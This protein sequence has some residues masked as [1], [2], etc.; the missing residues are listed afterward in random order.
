MSIRCDGHP[1]SSFPSM[2]G[3]AASVAGDRR[4]CRT[5]ALLVAWAIAACLLAS[6]SA[7]AQAPPKALRILVVYGVSPELPEVVSFTKELRSSLRRDA[8]NVEFYQ[9]YLDLERFPGF[10]PRLVEYFANKYR[11]EHVDAIVTI[12]SNAL[13]FG[14]ERLRAVLP[15]IPIVFAL[16]NDSQLGI[17]LPS[18]GV[19]GRFSPYSYAATLDMAQRLQPDAEQVA[20][21]GGVS[22][23][24][25][26]AVEQAVKAVQASP[27]RLHVI[28]LR[29]L[30]YGALLDRL[31]N[32]P[33]HTIAL[34]TSLR[35]DQAGQRFIPGE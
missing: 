32:L 23:F 24:D 35:Q 18:D 17:A 9:E 1:R 26:V 8:R 21:I 4:S 25:S 22:K 16:T 34:T 12:G 31:A 10:G 20:L 7:P 5:R 28:M 19:T 2:S 11:E 14:T 13:R 6:A 33:P 30:T 15:G 29:G 3:A 27:R